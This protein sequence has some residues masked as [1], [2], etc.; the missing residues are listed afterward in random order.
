MNLFRKPPLDST[1][2]GSPAASPP[3]VYKPVPEISLSA[4][5]KAL[6]KG[7]VNPRVDKILSELFDDRAAAEKALAT[8]RATAGAVSIKEGARVIQDASGFWRIVAGDPPDN[9]VSMLDGL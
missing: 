9:S 8:R 6:L 1:V 7:P 2:A 3:G 5:Q 4:E